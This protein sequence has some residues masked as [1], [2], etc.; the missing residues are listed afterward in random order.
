MTKEDNMNKMLRTIAVLMSVLMVFTSLVSCD[1]TDI[2]V[3]SD[4]TS[5]IVETSSDTSQPEK[6][7]SSAK[8]D[9]TSSEEEKNY[10]FEIIYPK[11]TA[12][13]LEITLTDADVKDY[14]A[15]INEA[16]NIVRSYKSSRLDEFRHAVYELLSIR[17]A[18]KAERDMA[19]LSYC[20]EMTDENWDKYMEAY[21]R[22]DDVSDSFWSFNSSVSNTTSIFSD[23]IKI[24]IAEEF[25]ELIAGRSDAY[26]DELERLE[27]EYNSLKN[28]G[29]DDK[30]LF[31]V[32]KKYFTTADKYA[33]SGSF[34]SYYEYET[35]I[36]RK[37]TDTADQRDAFR[38]YVKTYL[39]PLGKQLR[40]RYRI[41]DD[42]LRPDEYELSNR[43]LSDSY[44]SFE[45]NYLFDYFSSLP[46]SAAEIMLGVFDDDKIIIGDKDNSNNTA[47]V[48]TVG[49]TPICYFH[50]DKT[51]LD[52]MAHELGHYYANIVNDTT[53]FSYSL[54]ETHSTA[55]EMLL[56]SYLS[57]KLDNIAFDS[58]ETYMVFEYMYQIVANVIKDEF[59]EIISNTDPETLTLEGI[60]EI[61]NDLIDEYDVRDFSTNIVNNLTSY[62][63]THTVTYYGRNYCYAEGFMASFQI[64]AKSKTDYK[65]A[66]EIYKKLVEEPKNG[67][68]Y[69]ATIKNAGLTT[70]YDEQTYIEL[71]KLATLS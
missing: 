30:E 13:N 17:E 15:K 14:K 10:V 18:F 68:E 33:K 31:E 51:A 43:Y 27:G 50:K 24:I 56:Y 62:W 26:G 67:G 58:A 48:Y 5:E 20:C 70:P 64:Y 6:A 65:A 45:E 42:Q 22:F 28:S 16:K 61:M 29:A 8:T 32:Y 4:A 35:K 36:T 3:S 57:D 23:V 12:S 11:V 39:V 53:D 54:E 66:T 55:S 46:K 1:T 9:V 7:T 38:E 71:Q 37:R 41:F 49:K 34:K 60:Q 47:M 2:A 52:T 69:L 59:D 44:D 19:Y 25:G 40:T 21:N 63:K